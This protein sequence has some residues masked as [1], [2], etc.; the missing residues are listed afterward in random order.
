MY[1]FIVTENIRYFQSSQNTLYS[2]NNNNNI[3]YDE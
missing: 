1:I 2:I 3:L